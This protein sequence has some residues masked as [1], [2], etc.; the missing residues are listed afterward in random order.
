MSVRRPLRGHPWRTREAR[1]GHSFT[2]Q[3]CST[4]HCVPYFSLTHICFRMSLMRMST[5][6]GVGLSR[7][8]L[9]LPVRRRF[10]PTHRPRALG[11][12][13]ADTTSSV[14]Y[15]PDAIIVLA[16]GQ[17]RDGTNPKWVLARLI[18]AARLQQKY[19]TPV[20]CSGQVRRAHHIPHI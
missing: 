3:D 11:T 12:I 9:S 19:G 16:G 17:N 5:C 7:L 15:P 14:P 1:L 8:R 13:V 6:G 4:R 20:V 2:P 18:G 10:L